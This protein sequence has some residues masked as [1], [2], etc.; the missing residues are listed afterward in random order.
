ME[1]SKNHLSGWDDFKMSV[2]L[3]SLEKETISFP[4]LRLE[5]VSYLHY[6]PLFLE[7]REG[8]CIA[9]R[10]PSG[11]GKSLFLKVVADLFP[12]E[13]TLWLQGKSSTTF[14]PEAWRQQV[15]L[16]LPVS[17]WW[18]SSIENHFPILPS[19]EALEALGL[20]EPLLKKAPQSLSTGQLQRF[21]LL[22]LLAHEPKV[23]LLDEPTAHVDPKNA[24]RMETYVLEY[25]QAKKAGIIWV[26]HDEEQVSRMA[27]RF[28][29]FKKGVLMSESH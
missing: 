23:L 10:G 24:K 17:Q 5:D 18:A 28:F 14:T 27:T 20:T 4:L 3:D 22:R 7:L 21:A 16:L 15:G 26:T 6:G 1:V 19:K 29:H 12:H 25:Q 11:A 9:I 2:H 13:G 8:E